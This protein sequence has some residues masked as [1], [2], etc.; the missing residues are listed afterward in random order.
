MMIRPARRLDFWQ[1]LSKSWCI[2]EKKR[3]ILKKRAKKK[4][5]QARAGAKAPGAAEKVKLYGTGLSGLF[6][7]IFGYDSVPKAQAGN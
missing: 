6:K 1:A 7:A 3:N 5:S 2:P 4:P